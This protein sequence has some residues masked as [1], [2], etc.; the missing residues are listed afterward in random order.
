MTPYL[1]YTTQS[2]AEAF[3]SASSMFLAT[4]ERIGPNQYAVYVH[5]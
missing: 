2:Q 3:C 4:W 1:I 5:R